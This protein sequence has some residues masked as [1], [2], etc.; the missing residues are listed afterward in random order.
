LFPPSP[1]S[2]LA[3]LDAKL[4]LPWIQQ[5]GMVNFGMPRLGYQDCADLFDQHVGKS[6][7]FRVVHYRDIVPH[8][9]LRDLEY[10][11]V[12]TELWEPQ[13]QFNGTLKQCDGS[14][15]DE[16]CSDSVPVWRWNPHDHLTYLG[17]ATDNC[18]QR[19][20]PDEKDK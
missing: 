15:E 18:Q 17:I 10:H 12:G 6:S 7:A 14:G 2:G 11:H 8:Y 9:P 20:T 16:Q 4:A 13:E 3:A 19:M 1:G 5:V